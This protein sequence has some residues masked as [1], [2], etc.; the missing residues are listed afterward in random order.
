MRKVKF[1]VWEVVTPKTETTAAVRDWVEYEGLFHCWGLSGEE[2][3][4][5]GYSNTVA[6]VEMP[7]GTIKNPFCEYV[8]FIS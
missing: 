8:Q 7:D 1:K 4:G 5:G 2:V 6:I 3:E